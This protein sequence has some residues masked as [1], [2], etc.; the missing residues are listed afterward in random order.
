MSVIPAWQGI[1][2]FVAV[3]ETGSFTAAAQRLQL[4]TAQISRQVSAL[5]QRLGLPLLHR[6]TRKVSV[7]DQGKRYYQQCRQLLD[8]FENAENELLDQQTQPRGTLRLTAPITYGERILMPLLNR[9]LQQFPQMR[10]E[11]ELSNARMDL[12]DNGFDLAIRLGKLEDNRLRARKLAS[13][14]V[15]T[16]ASPAYI[17][18]YG[19]PYSLSELSQHNC[20]LGTLD[21]WR[22]VENQQPRAVRVSGRLRCNSGISLRDAALQDMGIVQLPEEYLLNP[23]R[24]GQ[25]QPVLEAF[26]P[27]AEGIWAVYPASRW[28]SPKTARLLDYL[29]TN[30]PQ[31]III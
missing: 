20:L 10:F 16:C 18:R 27:A 19:Q 7:S 4:S 12:I 9:F 24:Q 28:S 30:L 6:T 14:Q 5:E 21:H 31:Q 15:Y 13:R 25:L 17:R 29:S 11:V 8:G 1:A 22:F 2:E 3:V 23:I 26:R